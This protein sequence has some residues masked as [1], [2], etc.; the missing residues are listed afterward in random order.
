VKVP[1]LN[2]LPPVTP[3][4]RELVATLPGWFE[5]PHGLVAV[6]QCYGDITVSNGQIT[7]K[8]WESANMVTVTDMPGLAPG[9]RFYVNKKVEPLLRAALTACLALGNGYQILTLGCFAPRPKR[10]NGDL[11][12]HS[13]GV[14]IDINAATNPLASAPGFIQ[15]DIP[16]AWIAQFERHGWRWGGRFPRADAMHLQFLDGY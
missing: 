2:Y 10:V 6:K 16:D 7:T 5:P 12:T 8:G 3:I 11:S 9:R 15:R 4:D 13:W 1:N 14:A